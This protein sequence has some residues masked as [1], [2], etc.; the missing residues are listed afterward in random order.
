MKSLQQELRRWLLW[1]VVAPA[2]LALTACLVALAVVVS[3]APE[4]ATSWWWAVVLLLIVA[5]AAVVLLVLSWQRSA[6]YV[7]SLSNDVAAVGYW[8]MHTAFSKQPD[9]DPVLQQFPWVR[10]GAPSTNV[11]AV[12]FAS[13]WMERWRGDVLAQSA[14]MNEEISRDMLLAN[15]FQQ[16]MLNRPYPEVPAVHIEGRLRLEF[17]HR[18]NP[19][20]AVGGDFFDIIPIG[21]DCAGIFVTDVMGHGVRSALITA[22]LRALLSELQPQ[23]R[24]AA[25]FLKE[26]NREFS[27]IILSLP[28]SLFASA[29]YLVADTTSRIATYACAGHPP[30]F[31]IHRDRARV[32]RLANPAPKGAALGLIPQESYRGETVRLL[33]GHSFIFFTDGVY[34]CAN[35]DGEEY[36]LTRMEKVIQANIYRSTPEILDALMQSITTFVRGEPLADD[37]C[38]VAV[39][40]TTKPKPI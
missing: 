26:L 32:T 40:I 23:A 13:E 7:L 12:R 21:N 5:G 22:I 9:D 28:A 33:D 25:H 35:P 20:M 16:A 1:H 36:G 15:E 31:Q 27:D 34:E 2:G 30:P 14:R 29:F 17:H 8:L 38:L 3:A 37:L 10:G 19:A 11:P 4:E 18:Y 24:N 6:R 39:D